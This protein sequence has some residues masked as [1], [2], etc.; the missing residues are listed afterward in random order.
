VIVRALAWIGLL[1]SLLALAR[2]G[3][4]TWRR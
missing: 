1:A 3:W 4:R 2:M